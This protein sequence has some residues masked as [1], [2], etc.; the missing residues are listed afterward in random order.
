MQEDR[1]TATI[2]PKPKQ[3]RCPFEENLDYSDLN[4]EERARAN[5]KQIEELANLLGT[6]DFFKNY[7]NK[8]KDL[9]QI[10]LAMTVEEFN[11]GDI[12][13]KH[14]D[15]GDKFYIILEGSVGVLIPE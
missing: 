6:Y 14:D 9:Q 12:V 8:T 4:E 5:Y 15:T 11:E 1:L 2:Q 13:F 7:I 3:A 10:A